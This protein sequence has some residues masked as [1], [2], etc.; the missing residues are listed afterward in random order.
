MGVAK[1]YYRTCR[2][3]ANGSYSNASWGYVVHPQFAQSPRHYLSAF[4]LL[5]KDLLEV[6]EYVEPSDSNE[7]CY[8]FRI[9]ELLFRTCVEIEAN[10]KAILKENEYSKEGNMNI[11]DDYFKIQASHRL[12]SY[13]VKLPFWSGEKDFRTPFEAWTTSY[14]PLAWYQA[15]NDTK[16]DRH[17]SFEKASFVN[18]IDAMCGLVT[19]L[20]SQ[21]HTQQFSPLDPVLGLEGSG[22]GLESAIGGYFRVKFPDDWP[23]DQRYDFDWPALRD[24]E[25]PFESFGYSSV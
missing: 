12:S 1:P 17:Q 15:Y 13:K 6:F 7:N 9:Q 8:S 18:L 3:S 11:R 10:F 24:S 4:Y 20:S 14:E 16:H 22:D 25:K 23:E 5:Q 19:V 21:F 2:Q